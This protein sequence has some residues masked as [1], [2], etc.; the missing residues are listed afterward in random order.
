M[1]YTVKYKLK[2]QLFFRK[3]KNVKGDFIME[4]SPIPT[5]VIIKENEEQYHIPIKGTLFL[6]SKE[7]FI[8]IKNNM[9]NEIGQDIKIKK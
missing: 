4:K 8:V 6:Y 9:E 2:N 3:I 7:R 1:T 5:K